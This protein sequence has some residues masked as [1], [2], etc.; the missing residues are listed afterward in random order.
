MF[1]SMASGQE[2]ELI[3]KLEIK[4]SLSKLSGLDTDLSMQFAMVMYFV[5]SF[6]N[7]SN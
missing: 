7:T 3:S 5:P 2:R 1:L 6:T 4:L